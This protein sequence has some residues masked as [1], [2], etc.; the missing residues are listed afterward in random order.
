MFVHTAVSFQYTW[1]AVSELLRS[2]YWRS[3]DPLVICFQLMSEWCTPAVPLPSYA[4]PPLNRLFREWLAGPSFQFIISA[5]VGWANASQVIVYW[6]S[7]CMYGYSARYIYIYI[8]RDEYQH[9]CTYR[10][11]PCYYNPFLVALLWV[12]YGDA[13]ELIVVVTFFPPYSTLL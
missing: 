3:R 6:M 13:L 2:K 10:L 12:R 7:C 1:E 4:P 5:G 11:K 9:T 8:F